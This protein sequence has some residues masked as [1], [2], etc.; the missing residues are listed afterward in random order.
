MGSNLQQQRQDIKKEEHASPSVQTVSQNDSQKTGICPNCHAELP[1]E[2]LFYSE[3]GYSVKRHIC[4]KCGA[5]ASPT[6][7][8]CEACG[9][10]LLESK[11]KFCYAD[12]SSDVALFCPECGKPK[13]GIP[14]PNCGTLSI[15]DFCSKCGKPVT[16]EAIADLRL[17][18]DERAAAPGAT[19]KTFSSHQEARRWHN[20][21][22]P[23]AQTADIKAELAQLE[24]L[25]N[26]KPELETIENETPVSAKKPL[27]SDR[28]MNS[29]RQT[30]AVVEE[31]TRQRIEAERI[32]EEKRKAEEAERKRKEEERQRQIKEAQE[33]KEALER[34]LR[35][36]AWR[37]NAYG[38]IH[39]G[40][41]NECA[42]PSKGGQ[43][44]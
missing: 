42:D 44:V 7:D 10:W 33:R 5:P 18:R 35:A 25:I 16:E 2:A 29:I 12:L 20:A 15:F 28:Q 37:C 30:G 19:K 9:A 4:K 14:C 24:A 34:Q 43:W 27:F 22:R 3:C 17:A 36:R 26:S 38:A 1:E 11:C 31:I 13:D 41:P 6:A 8:I 40:G 39:P 23:D 32:A 21:H